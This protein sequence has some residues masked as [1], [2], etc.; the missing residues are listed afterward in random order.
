MVS[1][2][3]PKSQIWADDFDLLDSGDMITHIT[4]YPEM[5]RSIIDFFKVNFGLPADA[6]VREGRHM[7]VYL[8]TGIGDAC[9]KIEPGS[10]ISAE[11]GNII[12]RKLY[13]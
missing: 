11:S 1:R 2:Y 4:Y 8:P 7:Y 10:R 12:V 13:P 5:H 9:I 3:S 6:I